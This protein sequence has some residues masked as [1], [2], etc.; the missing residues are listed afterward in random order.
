M[1][2]SDQW[3]FDVDV[4]LAGAAAQGS[5]GPDAPPSFAYV[6]TCILP[7]DP[8]VDWESIAGSRKDVNLRVVVARTDDGKQNE[9]FEEDWVNCYGLGSLA[10]R[11]G[12]AVACGS[13]WPPDAWQLWHTPATATRFAFT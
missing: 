8:R 9:D 6:H 11:A 12:S 5:I 2:D 1:T 10:H 3:C 7:S 4:S 13:A